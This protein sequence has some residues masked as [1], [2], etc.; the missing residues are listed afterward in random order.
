ML[1]CNCF[2]LTVANYVLYITNHMDYEMEEDL[3]NGRP[4]HNPHADHD[5]V[6][7]EA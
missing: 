4:E 3:L 1:L 5:T 7:Y 2:L 6:L